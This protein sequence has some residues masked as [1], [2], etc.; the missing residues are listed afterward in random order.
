[1]LAVG[2]AGCGGSGGVPGRGATNGPGG[3]MG[4]SG[5]GMPMRTLPGTIAT[6]TT[7][8]GPGGEGEALFLSSGCGGCHTLAA[9][10][11]SGTAGPNLDRAR[12]S[13]QLVVQR[14]TDGVGAMPGYAGSLSSAQ[15]EA[16][17]RYVAD[18]TR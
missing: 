12:P 11:A 1:M 3:M 5:Q 2:V 16:I 4:D 17:A 14:V 9:A 10:G 6:T 7:A 13:Y 18:S 15:I 8:G